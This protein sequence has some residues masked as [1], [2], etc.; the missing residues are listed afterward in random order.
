[1][2]E[3]VVTGCGGRLDRAGLLALGR[4]YLAT[5]RDLDAGRRRDIPALLAML[6]DDIDYEIPFLATPAR[7]QGKAALLP[8]FEAMQGQFDGITYDVSGEF[9]DVDAQTIWIEMTS[10]RRIMPGGELYENRYAIAL[11][12]DDGLIRWLREYVNPLPAQEIS[13]RLKLA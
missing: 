4:R 13:R 12:C 10:S 11:G 2:T 8:F 7:W 5:L 1:M 3:N 6:H 9:V